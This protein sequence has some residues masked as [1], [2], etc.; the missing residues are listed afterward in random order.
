MTDD[1]AAVLEGCL[2]RVTYENPS[3]RYAVAKFRAGGRQRL[4]TITGYFG[5]TRPGEALRIHGNWE[6]H[7]RFGD[8]FRVQHFEI[9]PPAS[10]DGIRDLLASGAIAGVGSQLAGRLVAAF[11]AETLTVIAEEPERLEQI[12]GIGSTKARSIH[13]AWLEHASW[14]RLLQELAKMGIRASV[15]APLFS[16]YGDDAIGVI[17]DDPYRLVDDLPEIGFEA[18]DQMARHSDRPVDLLQRG[19]AAIRHLLYRQAAD[20]HTCIEETAVLQTCDAR[21]GIDFETARDCLEKMIQHGEVFIENIAQGRFVSPAHLYRAEVEIARRLSAMLA[22]PFE[23]VPLDGEQLSGLVQQSLSLE[24]SEN[25]LTTLEHLM[26]HRVAV[27]SGGPGT[28]KTTLIRSI[29]TVFE[30]QAKSVVLAAPTGRAARRLSQVTG[31][32][33]HTLHRLLEYQPGQE[34]FFRDQDRPLQAEA[35]IIDEVSMVDVELMQALLKAVSLRAML[36]L[37]GDAGQLPS[38]GPGNVLADL[39]RSEQVPVYYLTDMFRQEREGPIAVNAHRV[40]QGKLPL[41]IE[42]GDDEAAGYVYLEHEH[43]QQVVDEIVSWCRHEIPARF[44]L[45]PISDIQVLTPMHKGVAGT[46]NLNQ[47]LQRVLNPNATEIALAGYRFRLGDKVM[48]LV[49]NYQKEVFNGDIGVICDIDTAKNTLVVAFE[50]RRVRYEAAEVHELSAAYAISI[51]KSQGS[52]Y[53]AVVIPLVTQ[54]Y[55]LLQRN[56]L[57]T[58]LTRAQKLAVLIGSR[59]ALSMA[60]G[61]DQ[62]S[63]RLTWLAER[64][65]ESEI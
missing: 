56:V 6:T 37:V 2:E 34:L 53:P 15:A 25:Q 12:E 62:P 36:I 50:G 7:P 32:K 26:S 13:A 51:H 1:I 16:L 40:R 35:V 45:D 44:G 14:R 64:L 42:A 55:A 52:E 4:I 23:P 11:G 18:V 63:R 43:S 60:V 41:A 39:I 29:Y 20:G 57:Y 8:Q 19:C 24:L 54:H 9:A 10:T 65:R 5:G 22:L 48:H 47:V 31:R 30:H 27:V 46:V 21:Y 17:Q 33:A 49:N 61:R 28:G 58:A 3:N 59:R 38:V